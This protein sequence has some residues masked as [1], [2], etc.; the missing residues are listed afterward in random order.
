MTATLQFAG[1]VGVDPDRRSLRDL[2]QMFVGCQRLIRKQTIWQ[3]V[4]LFSEKLDVN[5]FLRCGS[6]AATD[7][8]PLVTDPELKAKVD[9]EVARIV[10]ARQ[11]REAESVAIAQQATQRPAVAAA[12]CPGCNGAK[13]IQRGRARMAC[14][15]CRGRGKV[16]G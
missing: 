15:R 5:E 7:A 6:S 12:A 14:P 8:G 16:G 4:A 10:A 11:A 13:F 2:W 3:S 1:A 9:E